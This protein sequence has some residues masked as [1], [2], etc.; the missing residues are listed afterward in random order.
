MTVHL[1]SFTANSATL[2]TPP[3]ELVPSRYALRLGDIDVM[4]I[5]DGVLPLPTQT[6]STNADPADREQ[7]ERL[8]PQRRVCPPARR[9]RVDD[10]RPRIPPGDEKDRAP[11]QEVPC[12]RR[13]QCGQGR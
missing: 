4:V 12:P 2:Q 10:Q 7:P 5:S 1:D 6:M 11:V 9:H 8:L 3:E 13:G